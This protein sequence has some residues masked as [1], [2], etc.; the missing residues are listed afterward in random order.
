MNKHFADFETNKK[1]KELG[2]N[3]VCIAYCWIDKDTFHWVRF[4][5]N[6]NRLPTR[7]SVPLWSQVKEWLWSEHKIWIK[8][9]E[10]KN[11]HLQF[12]YYIMQNN[13][14]IE[15]LDSKITKYD[16]PVTSEIE[17]IKKA[18]EYLYSQIK[19]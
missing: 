11:V 4:P 16:S 13:E 6:H 1:L 14:W 2:F 17:G 3:G 19:K 5:E 9:S 12:C 7:I 8:P 10:E 15:P 18:V